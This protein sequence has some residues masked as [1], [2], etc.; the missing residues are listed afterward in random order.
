MTLRKFVAVVVWLAGAVPAFAQA[1][2]P[3]KA[4]EKMVWITIGS[5]ALS[6]VRESFQSQG[7]V[8]PAPLR[9]KSGVAALRIPESQIDK[10]S[11]VMH[12]KLN[13]CAGFIAHDSEAKALA[14]VDSAGISQ[15]SVSAL[16]AYNINNAPS[17]NAM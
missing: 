8:L 15:Q 10:L 9:E 5:D 16:I 17:V 1:A 11:A 4:Q 6:K 12:E 7:L 13:R 3:A 14:E 2:Q